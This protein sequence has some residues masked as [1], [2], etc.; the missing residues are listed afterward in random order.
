MLRAKILVVDHELQMY[1]ALKSGLSHHGY[2]LHT[3]ATTLDALSLAGAHDYQAALVELTATGDEA[4]MPGLKA[5]CSSMPFIIVCSSE[6]FSIPKTVIDLADNALGKPLTLDSVRLML[7]RTVE[8]GL[9]RSRIRQL[10]YDACPMQPPSVSNESPEL[11]A[12]ALDAVLT[13]T[14]RKIVANMGV[15]GRGALHRAVLSYVEKLLLSIVL[16]ECRGNQL[17]SAE[18]LGINRNTLRKKLREFDI[19]SSR[20]SA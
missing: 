1:E 3:T 5:E 15:I 6:A 10:R 8:L 9:L 4:L 20:R 18:I 12:V 7:D 19:S 14:L 11:A 2:E 16:A 13:N 17:R